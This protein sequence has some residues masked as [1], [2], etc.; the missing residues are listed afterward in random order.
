[1]KLESYLLFKEILL[2]FSYILVV[3]RGY[4]LL[5]SICPMNVKN[6]KITLAIIAGY[7][8]A[9][10]FKNYFSKAKIWWLFAQMYKKSTDC[11][12]L[13]GSPDSVNTVYISK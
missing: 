2:I 8:L 9:T 4:I 11:F 10:V 12:V 6:W 13:D 1:M 7:I 3:S 5:I